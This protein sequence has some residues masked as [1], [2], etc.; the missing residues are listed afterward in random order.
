[1]IPLQAKYVPG[2]FTQGMFSL[3]N[4][5]AD[6]RSYVALEAKPKANNNP[7]LL[8]LCRWAPFIFHPSVF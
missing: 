7:R 1:M 6:L 5:N 4:S 3:N 8:L 2:L